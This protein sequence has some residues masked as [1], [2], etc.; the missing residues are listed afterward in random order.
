MKKLFI[1]IIFATTLLL[2]LAS[3]KSQQKVVIN[4]EVNSKNDGKML[5][6]PQSLDKFRT[7]PYSN[8]FSQ[9]YD[10][11]Q[12]DEKAINELKKEK[13][14]SFHIIT[15][16]GTWCGDS[17]R[18]FPRLIKIL[19]AI[20]Y[21]KDKLKIIA[22]NRKKESPSGEEGLFIIQR[23]PTI[24]LKKYGKEIG[25]ITEMPS[26]GYIERDLVE[27]T[28]KYDSSVKDLLKK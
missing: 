23:V 28:K 26:S 7:E 6:G 13:L 25:R 12:L 16:V 18:E 9:E 22:V 14:N 21:P 24:I 1:P 15:F 20:K 11:Y 2:S 3:C 8:W 27:I 5:L 19:D 17:H 4:R 10:D